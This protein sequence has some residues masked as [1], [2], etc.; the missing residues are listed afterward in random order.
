MFKSIED[1]QALRQRVC[2]CFERAALPGTSDKVLS[3]L[4]PLNVLPPFS[5]V[6]CL[7]SLPLSACICPPCPA[8]GVLMHVIAPAD[9]QFQPQQ[10]RQH[11]SM[12]S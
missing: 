6:L 1:A 8:C 4:Q 11:I 9:S 3:C 7:P 5:P 10:A 2:E 12:Q